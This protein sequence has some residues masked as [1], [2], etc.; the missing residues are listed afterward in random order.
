MLLGHSLIMQQIRD[1][2]IVGIEGRYG[3]YKTALAFRLAYELVKTGEFRHVVAN[4]PNSFQSDFKDIKLRNNELG[5]PTFLDTVFIL[6][7]GGIFL[8]NDREVKKFVAFLRKLNSILIIP[9]VLPLPQQAKVLTI[10]R[11]NDFQ[12]IGLPWLR[13][14]AYLNSGKTKEDY[15]FSWLFPSEIY[16]IYNTYAT[17]ADADE[18]ANFIFE[19][20]ATVSKAQGYTRTYADAYNKKADQNKPKIKIATTAREPRKKTSQDDRSGT[21]DLPE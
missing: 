21:L 1:F 4:L 7:E 2:R 8:D 10:A 19:Q 5:D 14:R 16:G 20:S 11:K 3:S 18:I 12:K 9:S 15:T 17:P 13:Y 6:D